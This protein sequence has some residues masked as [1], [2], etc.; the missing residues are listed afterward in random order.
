MKFT[1]EQV[2]AA[3]EAL[4]GGDGAAA[5]EILESLLTDAASGGAPADDKGAPPAAAGATGGNAEEPPPEMA[6][7]ARGVL[8]LF[9]GLD[10]ASVL[11]AI[12]ALKAGSD[13]AAADV[14]LLEAVERRALVGELVKLGREEPGT[15]WVDPDKTG[16][17]LV[18]VERLAK[19]DLAGLRKRVSI[20]RSTQGARQKTT[21]T[22]PAGGNGDTAPRK[23][24]R[25]ELAYCE[26]HKIT[27]EQFQARTRDAVRTRPT[28]ARQ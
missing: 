28:A 17:E 7:L 13:K 14:A 23:L 1:P 18:P 24:N 25:A 2:K 26:K 8:A 3:M 10:A 9:S 4:A 22:P 20:M 12:E 11:K 15:A 16:A 19:E 6:A 27:P 5:L 21:H